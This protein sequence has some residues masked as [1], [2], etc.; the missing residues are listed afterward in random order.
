MEEMNLSQLVRE[1]MK[2]TSTKAQIEAMDRLEAKVME[3][4]QKEMELQAIKTQLAEKAEQLTKKSLE[5][6]NV[7]FETQKQKE[8]FTGEIARF[9]DLENKYNELDKTIKTA[10]TAKDLSNY[11]NQVIKEFNDSKTSD[12]KM[13]TYVINNMD[14]DLKVRIFGDDQDSLKFSAP[15]VTEKTEDSLSSIKI[16]I[17]AIP[18]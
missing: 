17:Q 15:D 2:K 13:A 1:S 16:S 6:E 12:S 10:Y 11:L 4:D 3:F 9:S 14:V 7:K 18:K 8:Y 5:L